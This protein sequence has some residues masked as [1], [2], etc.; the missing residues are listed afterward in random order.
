MER[1]KKI[2]NK[3]NKIARAVASKYYTP[4]KVLLY[5]HPHRNDT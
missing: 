3:L 5:V 1:E 4:N 2:R